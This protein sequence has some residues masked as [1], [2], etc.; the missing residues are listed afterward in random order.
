MDP[1]PE[2]ATRWNQAADRQTVWMNQMREVHFLSR[3]HRIL[4]HRRLQRA[5]LAALTAQ[6]MRVA[7]VTHADRRGH[8]DN[9]DAVIAEVV[10]LPVM[11]LSEDF[12][13][14]FPPNWAQF[15][16]VGEGHDAAEARDIVQCV[17]QRCEEDVPKFKALGLSLFSWWWWFWVKGINFVDALLLTG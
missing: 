13:E 6:Y 10:Q 1:V 4:Q 5:R 11:H 9:E 8:V 17:V 2:Y 14:Q 7:E 16:T 3:H 12:L 15:L